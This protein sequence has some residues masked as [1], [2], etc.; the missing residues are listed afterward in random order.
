MRLLR[1]TARSSSHQEQVD[2]A[3]QVSQQSVFAAVSAEIRL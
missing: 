2:A 3:V 1:E